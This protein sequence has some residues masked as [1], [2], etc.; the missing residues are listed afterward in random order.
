MKIG[1]F[2]NTNNSPFMLARAMRRLGYEVIV[3]VDKPVSV[4]KGLHRPEYRYQDIS[5][6]YPD[7]IHDASPISISRIVNAQSLG[8]KIRSL[9]N[10]LC[11]PSWS[12]S[13]N[14]RQLAQLVGLL[15]T[16]DF[17]VLN[18]WGPSLAKA[19]GLPH[20]AILTGSDLDSF[21]RL[22]YTHSLVC[23]NLPLQPSFIRDHCVRH[24]LSRHFRLLVRDQRE[25]IRT[26]R[27][28]VYMAR[29]LVP[30]GDQILDDLG[31]TDAQRLIFFMA[32]LERIRFQPQPKNDVVRAFC[33]AR[34][35]WDK[36][37]PPYLGSELDYK[38]SDI[39]IRGLG[40]FFRKTR[41][42][43]N[44]RFVKKGEHIPQTIKLIEEEGI[45]GLVSWSEELTQAEV[46]KEYHQADLVFDQFG[47]SVVG[48]GGLDA[49]A[50][51]RP[52]I[53]N[54]RPEIIE[55]ITGEP[56]PICQAATP[57]EVCAQLERLVSS[58]EER[59]RVGLQSRRYVE[60]HFSP[61][62]AARKCLE[63]LTGNPLP[64][65]RA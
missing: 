19:I 63:R 21:A 30:G 65:G 33:V 9:A 1:F 55:R 4:N 59:E 56:S 22:D 2:G 60:K 47:R 40:L 46:L 6:P 35:H 57:E 43:L 61:E 23:A 37:A 14:P 12:R 52:L 11:R 29:G 41:L 13:Q 51:G 45:A 16:C 53:A 10:L 50:T 3:I 54:G 24:L 17:V 58:R 62:Q 31:V 7:W 18:E 42:P 25:G 28:V 36:S 48:V 8:E 39:M 32:D 38:G 34:F 64:R 15:R 27:A 49:M 44:L 5:L 26:A 20:I